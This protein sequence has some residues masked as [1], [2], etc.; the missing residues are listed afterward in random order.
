MKS[1]RLGRLSHAQR[2]EL[3]RQLKDVV[4][5]ADLIAQA[6]MSLARQFFLCV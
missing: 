3:N 1:H 5:A 4:E 6:T 2:A